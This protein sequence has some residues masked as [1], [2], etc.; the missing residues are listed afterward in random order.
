[1]RRHPEFPRYRK[2]QGP[3]DPTV[4]GEN[5]RFL[6]SGGIRTKAT[7]FLQDFLTE[8]MACDPES[9]AVRRL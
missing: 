8:L 9:L 1:M 7:C 3:T 5:R 4:T 2:L 6:Q